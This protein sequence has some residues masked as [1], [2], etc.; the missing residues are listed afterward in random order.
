MNEVYIVKRQDPL[1]DNVEVFSDHRLAEEWARHI[2]GYIETEPIIDRE[3]LDAFKES[4]PSQEEYYS[5]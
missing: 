3:M 5:S 1:N 2:Q 4:I